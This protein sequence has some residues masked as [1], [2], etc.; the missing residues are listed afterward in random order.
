MSFCLN[1]TNLHTRALHA[2]T[3]SGQDELIGELCHCGYCD[4]SWYFNKNIDDTCQI[5][6]REDC[7]VSKNGDVEFIEVCYDD[8]K[9][10]KKHARRANRNNTFMKTNEN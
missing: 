9:T 10:R 4:I 7:L 1:S 5:C 8:K 2:V 3:E 6:R